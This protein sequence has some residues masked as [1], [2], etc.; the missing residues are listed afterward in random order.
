MLFFIFLKKKWN[1]NEYIYSLIIIL[2]IKIKVLKMGIL[3]YKNNILIK[4]KNIFKKKLFFFVVVPSLLY[5]YFLSFF[6][7]IKL[8]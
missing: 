7:N 3:L 2:N 5:L 8:P 1:K 6:I 4:I